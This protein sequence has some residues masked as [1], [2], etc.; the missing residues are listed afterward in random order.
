MPLI[1]HEAVKSIGNEA[2]PGWQPMLEELNL[3]LEKIDPNYTWV[4]IKQKFCTL[5]FYYHSTY[6]YGSPEVERINDLIAHA[7]AKS[8]T[9]CEHCGNECESQSYGLV[10]C[11]PCTAYRELRYKK[12]IVLI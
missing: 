10:L 8:A 6:H 11:Q 4:Q 3:E 12:N 1:D 5:R 9:I 2:G 7:E